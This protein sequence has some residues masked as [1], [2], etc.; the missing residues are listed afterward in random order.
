MKL[1]DLARFAIEMRGESTRGLYGERLFHRALTLRGGGYNGAG[2]FPI[3][4]ETAMYKTLLAAYATQPLTWRRFCGTRPVQDFRAATF[5][6]NGSL[7]H[8]R[9]RLRARGVQDEADPRRREGAG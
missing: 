9:Q 6:R 2:D 4:L 1:S 3:L 7:R 8:A 5:Y